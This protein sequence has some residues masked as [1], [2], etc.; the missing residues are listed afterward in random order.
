MLLKRIEAPTLQ[1]AL[2]SVREECGDDALVVE[3]RIVFLNES[4]E[5]VVEA[6]ASRGSGEASRK[7]DISPPVKFWRAY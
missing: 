2:D 4:S 7:A 3:A 6:E 1:K 5:L